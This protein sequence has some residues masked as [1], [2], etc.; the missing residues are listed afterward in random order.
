M[1]RDDIIEYSLDA[2][3]SEEVGKA[4]RK[5]ILKVT[6]ILTLITILEVVV[7]ATAGRATTSG[8]TWQ[9]IKW[10]YIVLT[11]IKAGY[12]VLVFMHLGDEKKSLKYVILVPYILFIIYL[13]FICLMEALAVGDAWATYGG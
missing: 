2:H 12:I 9:M 13:I 4:I 5:K 8:M 6:V 10:G 7:G 3:H 11:L 1:E